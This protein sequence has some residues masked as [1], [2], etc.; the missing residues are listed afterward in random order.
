V[1]PTR[2]AWFSDAG[3]VETQVTDRAGLTAPTA[4]P[5]II[6]EY[7]AT[8]LVP[9]GTRAWVDGFGNIVMTVDGMV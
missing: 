3:W 5:L 1:P 6:Q 9:R 2:S 8:C 7:D 4:G